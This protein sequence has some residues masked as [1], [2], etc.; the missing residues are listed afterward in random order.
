MTT[1]LPVK[2]INE[3]ARL[4]SF[5]YHGD[6]GLD[7]YP[8][9]KFSLAPAERIIVPIG[10]AIE[11]P[12][13][14]EGQIRPRSGLALNYG[15]TVLNAPGTIDT[16]YRGEIKV[17]LINHGSGIYENSGEAIAQLVIKPIC[18]VEAKVV[19]ELSSSRQSLVSE[20]GDQGFGS[21]DELTRNGNK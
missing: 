7:L 12:S 19:V 18:L 14:Y 17:L 5:A 4:P 15:V 13:G 6:A 3:N 9:N 8:V 20:R 2:I 16:F 21:S 11:L 1:P 10:I